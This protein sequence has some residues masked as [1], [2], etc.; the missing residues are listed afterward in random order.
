MERWSIGC[1]GLV[2]SEVIRQMAADGS[3]FRVARPTFLPADAVVPNP[4]WLRPTSADVDEGEQRGRPPGLSIWDHGSTTVPQARAI[5]GDPPECPAFG[6]GVGEAV[7]VG[8]SMEVTLTALYDPIEGE[9]PPPGGE[10]HGLLEG[11]HRPAGAPKARY[12]ALRAALAG[13]ARRFAG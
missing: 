2:M 12:K 5:T 6:M 7:A 8:A 1:N 4:D 11:L 3:W 13:R 9:P 10:G